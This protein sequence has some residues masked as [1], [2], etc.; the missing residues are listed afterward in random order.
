LGPLKY[1]GEVIEREK[2]NEQERGR[3]RERGAGCGSL[4]SED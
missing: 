2:G 1:G 3:Q 4:C